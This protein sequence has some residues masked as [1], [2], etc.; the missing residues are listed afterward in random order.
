MSKL[1]FDVI[2]CVRCTSVARS[3]P[4][5]PGERPR[6]D[7]STMRIPDSTRCGR[8]VSSSSSVERGR[9]ASAAE[10]VRRGGAGTVEGD[11]PPGVDATDRDAVVEEDGSVDDPADPGADVP[12]VTADPAADDSSPDVVPAALAA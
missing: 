10:G 8:S 4:A 3:P 12:A 2:A 1:P 5:A 11:E 9:G 6:R 7:A